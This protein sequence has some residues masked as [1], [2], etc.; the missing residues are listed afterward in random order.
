[1]LKSGADINLKNQSGNTALATAS[2]SGNKEIVELLLKSRANPNIKNGQGDTTLTLALQ[3]GYE[4]IVEILLKSGADPNIIS[5]K[6][7]DKRMKKKVKI[8][9]EGC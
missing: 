6:G 1:L 8:R 4:E 3:N 2:G 5:E 7:R 9:E